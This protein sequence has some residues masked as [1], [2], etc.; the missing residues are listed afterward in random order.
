MDY[1]KGSLIYY[2]QGLG[3]KEVA[4]RAAVSAKTANVT[5]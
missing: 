3:E 2:Q 4:A 5:G 1:T